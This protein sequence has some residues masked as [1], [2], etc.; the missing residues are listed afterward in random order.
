MCWV[1]S[2]PCAWIHTPPSLRHAL[3]RFVS[4]SSPQCA[5]PC[6]LSLKVACLF[7]QGICSPIF[8]HFLLLDTC[9]VWDLRLK[10]EILKV[11]FLICSPLSLSRIS[12]RVLDPP[13]ADDIA[14]VA[15]IGL[16]PILTLLQNYLD[17]ALAPPL[18]AHAPPSNEYI[19]DVVT[20][21]VPR[22][23]HLTQCR[24][25]FGL[26]H[27]VIIFCRFTCTKAHYFAHGHQVMHR[28]VVDGV[29]TGVTAEVQQGL[30]VYK[31]RNELVKLIFRCNSTSL[32]RNSCK[33]HH[34]MNSS[35][36]LFETSR[37]YLGAM[38]MAETARST[39]M[40]LVEYLAKI[41]KACAIVGVEEI[42]LTYAECELEV[43]AEEEHST[44]TELWPE[45]R[46][47]KGGTLHETNTRFFALAVELATQVRIITPFLAI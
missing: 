18:H 41:D 45:I 43:N 46:G 44:G 13:C 28:I 30:R 31:Q 19:M 17:N 39:M 4:A 38:R 29:R 11:H 21:S 36:L 40:E 1:S 15:G 32:T 14:Q 33:L 42:S 23:H 24:A 27:A 2:S 35:L 25:V 8:L 3:A 34:S 9:N 7:S 26:R 37:R 20:V 12:C 16:A 22:T 6:R 47:P 5:R 10:Q